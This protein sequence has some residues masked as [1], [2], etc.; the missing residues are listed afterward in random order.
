MMNTQSTTFFST[1]LCLLAMLTGCGKQP[2]VVGKQEE[3]A[4]ADVLVLDDAA[5]K[6]AGIVVTPLQA[7]ASPKWLTAPGEVKSNEYRAAL[8]TTRIA[9]QVVRRHAK[10]GDHVKQDQPLVT[11]T[12]VEVAEVQ[13]EAQLKATEW[14]RVQELTE[15]VVGA[16]R[17][18]EARVAAEQAR[19][20][21]VAYG[22]SN[23]E[24]NASART[25]LGEFTLI[26][27]KAGTILRDRFTEG[28]RIDA[29][30]ELFYIA[31]ESAV[32]V[33]ANVSPVDAE[34]V[35]EDGKAHIKVGDQWL[36]GT[37]VQK[38]HLIDEATRT[39]P[40]RIQIDAS[41]DLLHA[42]EFVDC[43]IEV[44]QLDEAL[45]VANDAIY[46]GTDKQWAVFVQESAQHYRRVRVRIVA[47]L[48][49]SKQVEG[50]AAG[51]KLVTQGAFFLNAELMK[52]SFAEQE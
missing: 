19:A 13:G 36:N 24:A 11:L 37:V 50:V 17:Y 30:R 25:P 32:W 3:A 9:A 27:P 1:V 21:L 33:E 39:I 31:D 16:R 20:K 14:S 42:G 26:A 44:G 46:E 7:V 22:V 38:H 28:E 51:A 52:A 23:A 48:G 49:D 34:R 47:D 6:L 10:L 40:V 45:V 15:A 43:R 5:A 41:G 4:D 35:V 29:G 8:V 2:E 18:T 12:S